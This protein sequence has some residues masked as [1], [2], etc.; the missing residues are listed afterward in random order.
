ML[1]CLLMV[2]LFFCQVNGQ[3]LGNL[4]GHK[5]VEIRGSLSAGVMFYGAN[6]IQNRRKPFTWYLSGAPT[7]KIYGITMPFSLTVSEQE[8]RF[9]QPFNQYGVSPYYKWIKLHLGYRNVRF[10]DFT[11]AGANFLG[12]GVELTP[13]KLRLGFI[14]GRFARAIEEDSSGGDPR[15]RYLRP[16]Y[17]RMGWAA[18]VGFGKP[19]GYFD[20]SVFKASDII[21][22]IKR[23]SLRS[24]ITPMENV[25]AGL[26][27][28]FGLLKQ[29]LLF[30]FELAGSVLTRDMART[31]LETD[32]S[33]LQMLLNLIAVN[34][35]TA[36]FKALKG[37]SSYQFKGG[38][39]GVQYQRIDPD[40]QSLGAYFFQSDVEQITV[41][42]SYA[43]LKGKLNLSGSYGTQ[44]DNLNGKKSATTHRTIGSLN[45]SSMPVNGLN[46]GLS[47]SNFGVGQSRGIGDLFNDSLAISVVNAAYG[48]NIS[49]TKGTKVHT[50]SLNFSANYQNTN[51]QNQF[52]RQFSGASSMMAALSYNTSFVP[53]KMTGSLSASYVVI[54]TGGRKMVNIGPSLNV[55]R[56][57]LKGKLRVSINHNSQFRNVNGAQDGYMS[58]TG[59]TGGVQQGK[60]SLNLSG[61]LLINRYKAQSDAV[62]YRNFNE[63]RG[64]VIYGF[65]F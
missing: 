64:N 62:N 30:D 17:Q 29:K 58:N 35:T 31:D 60:Q 21:S 25:A 23:P 37:N 12:G 11:L 53:K 3:D 52:T 61:N 26:K 57:L 49:Y 18:K 43:M 7:L 33:G 10:G 40:Y 39:L 47:Y 42:S 20:L 44:H 51:D 9:S 4:R 6:G 50:H 14:Y 8:R 15:Y 55:G 32:H 5:P 63:F 24:R 1:C 13:G 54:N 16:T 41:S 45:V 19:K 36:F 59:I 2:L 22:S 28:H 48:G 65:R 38:R 27:N 34:E 46:V 56:Q